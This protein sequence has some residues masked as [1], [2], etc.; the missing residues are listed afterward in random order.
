MSIH[1]RFRR[2]LLFILLYS[3]AASAQQ[4]A[5]PARSGGGKIYLDVVVASKSGSPVGGLQQQDFTLLDNNAPRTIESFEAVNGREAP[6][7][8]LLVIDAVNATYETV[9]FER[10]EIDKFLRTDG[11]RLSYPTALAILTDKGPQ[12]VGDLSSD[13]NALSAAL[14]RDDVGLRSIRRSA[15]IEGDRERLD[16]S[17]QA[18]SKLAVNGSPRKSRRI[19]LWVSPGWPF[20]AG[21]STELETKQQQY[22]F[23]NIVDLSTQ[24]LQSR[25]TIY[26]VDPMAEGSITR[27]S[28]YKEFTKAVTKPSQVQI[29]NLGLQV[30]AVQSGGLALTYSNNLAGSLSEGLA[31]T[32]PYYEISFDPPSENRPDEYHRLEIKLAKP[33]LIARTRQGYYAGP[34]AAN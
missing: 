28:Y 29:G 15:G 11:G 9:S 27:G 20:L 2:F 23:T 3:C 24:L 8:V 19:M 12:I 22:I 13:G 10:I 4:Q 18:L 25:I 21:A 17:L 5:R 31:S 33:G 1:R 34:N 32:A 16:I 26:S 6:T 7:D 30:L 14:D